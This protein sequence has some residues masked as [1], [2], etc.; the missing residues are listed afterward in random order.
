M[1]IKDLDLTNRKFS[2]LRVIEKTNKFDALNYPIWKCICDCGNI[3]YTSSY[4]LIRSYTKSCG[5]YRMN[6]MK[7]RS[8]RMT[9]KHVK[10]S[11]E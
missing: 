5:C 3:V 2:S 6:R 9:W 4:R 11:I 1:S 8:G 10:N 7:Q